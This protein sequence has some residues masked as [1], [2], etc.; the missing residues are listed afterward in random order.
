VEGINIDHFNKLVQEALSYEIGMNPTWSQEGAR[1]LY[2]FIPKVR[3]ICARLEE[4]LLE[5]ARI[6]VKMVAAK[7][8]LEFNIEKK[9][10]EAV[11]QTVPELLGKGINWEERASVRRTMTVDM[12]LKLN[13]VQNAIDV[14]DV[15]H[16]AVERRYMLFLQAKGDANA[17][18]SLLRT[19]NILG[20]IE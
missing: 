6:K 16:K 18:A 7:R 14:V 5:F 12:R 8:S 4:I 20:E 13:E 19:G 11:A 17:M 15:Y 3:G 2:Q 10:D 1:E 9:Q